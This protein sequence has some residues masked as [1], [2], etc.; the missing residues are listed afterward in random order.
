MPSARDTGVQQCA[1]ANSLTGRP[2]CLQHYSAGTVAAAETEGQQHSQA[3]TPRFPQHSRMTPCQQ[4]AG[5]KSCRQMFTIIV[6][7]FLVNKLAISS[8]PAE[9]IDILKDS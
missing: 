4:M 2:T 3:C 8:D 7:A 5:R 9:T 1:K 6:A